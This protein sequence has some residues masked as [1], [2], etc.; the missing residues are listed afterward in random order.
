MTAAAKTIYDFF[1]IKNVSKFQVNNSSSFHSHATHTLGTDSGIDSNRTP[2]C[3]STCSIVLTAC[4]DVPSSNKKFE[5][6]DSSLKTEAND[7]LDLLDSKDAAVQT[8]DCEVI[9]TRDLPERK[10]R[11]KQMQE[12]R[13]LVEESRECERQIISVFFL[14]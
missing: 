5:D 10:E 3:I 4:T 2:Q 7:T 6:F 8:S 12:L 9:Y 1:Y 14:L 11:E 13:K